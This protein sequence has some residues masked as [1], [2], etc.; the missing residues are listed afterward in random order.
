MSPQTV[1]AGYSPTDNSIN[2]PAG[3]LGGAVY[4][5]EASDARKL[6]GIGMVIGH[7]I[8]HGFDDMGSQFDKD[9]NLL[10]WWTEED[11]AAFDE[12]T[13]KVSA[14]FSRFEVLPDV[15]VNGELT[16]GEAVADLGSMS[17]MMEIAKDIPDFDYEAFFKNYAQLWR[18]LRTAEGVE[19]AARTDPHPPNFLRTNAIVQQFEEFY[20]TFGVTEGDGMYLPI[21]ERLSVW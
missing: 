13:A 21:E 10:N 7:E 17:C 11:R 19:N 18:R 5:P 4:D 12:R 14:Y 15:F 1:N 2:I 20:D 9:G 6:S 16:K 8:S 3:I